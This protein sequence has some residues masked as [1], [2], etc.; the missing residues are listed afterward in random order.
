MYNFVAFVA[1][2]FAL[3]AVL[4]VDFCFTIAYFFAGIYMVSRMWS[5]RVVKQL[6]IRRD[7]TQRAFLGDEMDVTANPPPISW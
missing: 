3:A 4:R 7:L 1:V 6:T 5:K 2:L